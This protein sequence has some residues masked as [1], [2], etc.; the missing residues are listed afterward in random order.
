MKGRLQANLKCKGEKEATK[1][2]P[3]DMGN[4]TRIRD[5]WLYFKLAE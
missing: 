2:G 1:R 3:G 5:M 4:R